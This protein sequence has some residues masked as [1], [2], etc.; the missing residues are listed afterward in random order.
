MDSILVWLGIGAAALVTLG[1]LLLRIFD[2]GKKAERG[3]SAE[4]EL[5]Q[6]EIIDK[7][8][9]DAIMAGDRVVRN[10]AGLRDDDGHKRKP[11][12]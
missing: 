8:T 1:S 11:R 6:N 12:P 2:A 7:K 3:E 10:P 9:A 4:Q 5:I